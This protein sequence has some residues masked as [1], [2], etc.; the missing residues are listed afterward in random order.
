MIEQI[1]ASNTFEELK[2]VV[3]SIFSEIDDNI[4]ATSTQINT[5]QEGIETRG[6]D[7]V[8]AIQANN[9]DKKQL[10]EL[11]E[12][13]VN[14][15]KK[16]AELVAEYGSTIYAQVSKVYSIYE[17]KFDTENLDIAKNSIIDLWNQIL[18]IEED[19]KNR[20]QTDN[21]NNRAKLVQFKPYVNDE[22]NNKIGWLGSGVSG[23]PFSR[24][25]KDNQLP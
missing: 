8:E 12:F 5:L 7:S 6:N 19:Y 17:R 11:R 24:M 9:A 13:Y 14:R 25:I 21:N 3:E 4:E 22:H 2:T 20:K 16:R 23:V 10:E 18:A 1:K 15:L